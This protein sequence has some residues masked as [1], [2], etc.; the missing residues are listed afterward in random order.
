MTA[1]K[2]LGI[3]DRVK[4]RREWLQSVG[5]ITGP[6]PFARGSITALQ[7]VGPITLATIA[8]D[9]N[10]PVVMPTKANVNN[11]TFAN[12]PERV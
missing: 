1:T 11:L 6:M 4:Y 12:D 2:Q 7:S 3:G 8:W 9:G 5:C 10:D